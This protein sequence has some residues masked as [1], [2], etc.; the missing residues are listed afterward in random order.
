[1]LALNEGQQR[2]AKAPRTEKK[3]GDGDDDSD[4]ETGILSKS[5]L[6][7]IPSIDG[8][9]FSSDSKSGGFSRM[10]EVNF[11][12][13]IMDPGLFSVVVDNLVI[14]A[15]V[16]ERLR[17]RSEPGLASAVGSTYPNL[18]GLRRLIG[19]PVYDDEDKLIMALLGKFEFFDRSKLALQDFL[20]GHSPAFFGR[21]PSAEGR[22]RI[23]DA[24][25][26][27][28]MFFRIVCDSSFEGV[29]LTLFRS[30]EADATELD[31]FGDFFLSEEVHRLL[32]LWSTEVRGDLRSKTF[33]LLQLNTQDGCA[34]LLSAYCEQWVAG[35]NKLEVFPHNRFYG[36]GGIASR[37]IRR[38][39]P[40]KPPLLPLVE[41]I[42]HGVDGGRP[43]AAGAKKPCLH[44][45][46]ELLGI[47]TKDG[48]VHKCY[49]Q[50][51][52][53]GLH[54]LA[55]GELSSRNIADVMASP[56]SALKAE[57][58]KLLKEKRDLTNTGAEKK[59]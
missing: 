24:L 46:A 52:C 18:V 40:G 38:A 23:C 5:S 28:E 35:L 16:V 49:R 13:R 6:Y 36:Q 42:H 32:V 1:M 30:F 34:K 45:L 15:Q 50:S 21:S 31:S 3:S 19:F 33:P 54:F 57:I 53:S 26:G 22:A 10:K 25:R 48:S 14:D 39:V 51:G 59:K 7:G 56:D 11:L 44:A 58:V 9:L 37:V 29:F 2:A 4:D 27:V 17:F 20:R 47:V 41:K 43:A 12:I 55:L 8:R